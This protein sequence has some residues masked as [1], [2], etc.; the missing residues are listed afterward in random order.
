[1][2]DAGRVRPIFKWPG[3]KFKLLDPI[4]E[5]LPSGTRLV[6][7][8]VGS[9]CVFLNTAY[10]A[11]LLCDV[12]EDVIGFYRR[13]TAEGAA[14]VAGCRALFADGNGAETYYERRERFNI[15]PPGDERAELFLYLNRHGYNGLIRYN[16]K[17]GYNVPFGRF[18]KPYFPEYEM[19]AFLAKAE[20]VRVEFAAAD[21]RE[22]FARLG[23]GDVVYCDPPYYPL[24][25]TANFTSYAG[26]TFGLAEQ[27]ELAALMERAAADG[28][29]VVASNHD[30]PAVRE[31]YAGAG[32][33]RSLR[34]QRS[35][36]CDK[37]NRG[38]ADEILAVF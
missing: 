37:N 8:F 27:G 24:S 6:E 22:T 3:G 14:F 30:L 18:A 12:N 36:S 34:V 25:T 20:K 35:I 2:T 1:M 29:R 21:F 4:I 15:L 19:L 38:T 17:G 23:P 5:E 9:G 31:M 26:N 32:S 7:P 11:Y 28:V 16:S 10:D 13:L 33:L